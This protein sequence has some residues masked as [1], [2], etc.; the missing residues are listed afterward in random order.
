MATG[1]QQLALII[2]A[3]DKASANL[4][5]VGGNMRSL[6]SQAAQLRNRFLSLSAALGFAGISVYAAGNAFRGYLKGLQ[7]VDQAGEN[8]RNRLMLMGLSADR[9]NSTISTLRNNISG[10]AFSAMAGMSA[11]TAKLFN[12]LGADAQEQVTTMAKKLEKLGVDP[13]AAIEALTEAQKGNFTQISSLM[14]QTI[15]SWE[16]IDS[17][18]ATA[19]T[20]MRAN[21]TDL[22]RAQ[23]QLGTSFASLTPVFE[24]VAY[25][26]TTS[27]AAIIRIFT[28]VIPEAIANVILF[29]QSLGATMVQEWRDSWVSGIIG[30]IPGFIQ[31][32]GEGISHWW[33]GVTERWNGLMGGIGSAWD[34]AWGFITEGIP[35]FLG[36]IWDAISGWFSSIFGPMWDRVT[37]F[38]STAWSNVWGGLVGTVQR[39]LSWIWTAIQDSPVFKFFSAIASGIGSLFSK[40]G[41]IFSNVKDFLGFEHGGVVPGP[42]GAPTLAM[43]HGGERITPAGGIGGGT[44][45]VIPVQIGDREIT[46]LVLDILGGQVR[47]RAPSL[48]M[49]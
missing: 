12:L 21:M 30:A 6:E 22:D 5:A 17:T 28:D 31:R 36:N 4:R 34:K 2:E 46:R 26:L 35:G 44:T 29:F 3:R 37:G 18:V 19:T 45:V 13:K 23:E 10:T 16:Q 41:D 1:E 27:A 24:M 42:M 39:V 8:L 43:V 49:G 47:L 38:I 20:T 9:V 15:T 48:G 32:I 40:A 7:E 11:E 14:G 25:G 33:G